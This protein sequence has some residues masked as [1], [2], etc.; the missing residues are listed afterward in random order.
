MERFSRA[1][2]FVISL[3]ILL[4]ALR[5]FEHDTTIYSICM[6]TEPGPYWA[7]RCMVTDGSL[8]TFLRLSRPFW[9]VF[10]PLADL[11][12]Q[13]LLPGAALILLHIGFNREPII[14]TQP[15]EHNRFGRSLR[16]QV[17]SKNK[18][19][20]KPIFRLKF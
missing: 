18:P 15:D 13:F 16:D 11:F 2:L 5:F 10:L 3:S 9:K 1:I 14:D 4:G 6:D 17:Q 12:A 20:V 7:Q 19:E 8:V